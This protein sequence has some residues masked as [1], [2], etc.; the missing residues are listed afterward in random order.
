[1]ATATS[2]DEAGTCD[3]LDAGGAGVTTT[4]VRVVSTVARAL[5]RGTAGA[6]TQVE[7]VSMVDRWR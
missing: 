2:S 3:G 1:M 5:L 6:A 7:R 4:D